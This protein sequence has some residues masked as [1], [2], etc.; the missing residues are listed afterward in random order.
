MTGRERP[1]AGRL[2]VRSIVLAAGQ[3]LAP[4]EIAWDERGRITSLRRARRA[5]VDAC[6]LPGLVD[7]H[8]HLGIAALAGSVPRAFVPWAE[9]VMAAQGGLGPPQHRRQVRQAVRELLADGVT[10]FGEIDSSGHSLHELAATPAAGRCYREL[11]G[12][13]L[14]PVDSVRLVRQRRTAGRGAMASGWS[15]HAPYSVSAALFAAALAT[16][17][18]LAVHCAETAAEQQLLHTGRGPFRALLERLGRWPSGW[19][20]PRMGAVRWLAQL[21]VL[22][23]RTHLVHC[24]ELERGDVGRIAAAGTGI[25][26]CPGTIE[27]FG[28]TPPPVPRWLA[29]GIPVAL[30]TDSRASN[31]GWSLR[32]E[33]Q[34]AAQYWPE[35]CPGQLLAMATEHGGA[36]LG[37]RGLGRLRRA[38]RADF[39]AIAGDGSPAQ[40]LAEFV[41]GRR[42][43]RFVVVGGVRLAAAA[44]RR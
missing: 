16:G 36:V 41:Q 2:L 34:L 27:W 29:A 24:Q 35:L 9:A 7:A 14:G 23:P 33:L 13:H 37:R 15:P 6:L 22:G 44:G 11:T 17:R 30:G 20:A 21:G 32:R 40:A 25:V 3:V 39:V 42:A 4:G 28:R 10:A 8:V 43:P 18:H 31:R 1:V 26:V 5:E 12:F 38:G 19:R